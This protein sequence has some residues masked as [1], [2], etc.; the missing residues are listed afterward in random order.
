[1][2]IIRVFF[3]INY[4]TVFENKTKMKKYTYYVTQNNTIF[5]ASRISM[6]ISVKQ[7]HFNT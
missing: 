5:V 7:Y 1:M 2:K 4:V 6:S 3:H